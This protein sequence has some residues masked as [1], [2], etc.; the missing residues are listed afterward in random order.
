MPNRNNALRWMYS[1][2]TY[3]VNGLLAQDVE[4]TSDSA[5]N[6]AISDAFRVSK[7]KVWIR[8]SSF[9]AGDE[10][11]VGIADGLIA[12][13][14]IEESL[15]ARPTQQADDPATDRA[16]RPVWP[17]TFLVGENGEDAFSQEPL[18]IVVNH[19]FTPEGGMA[20]WFYN[21][22]AS[23]P[24]ISGDVRIFAKIYGV[25]VRS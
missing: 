10:V 1:N 25:W 8:S 23:N 20:W 22:D 5:V 2:Q 3:Q 24:I 16:M 18:D 9:T 17:V 19:T 12:A 15:E 4:S 7:M 21:P 14:E 11:I 6:T 13:T